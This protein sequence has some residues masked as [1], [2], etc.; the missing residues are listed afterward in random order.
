MSCRLTYEDS[1]VALDAV[2]VLA[3]PLAI[4]AIVTVRAFARFFMLVCVTRGTRP[5]DE[6]RSSER[7]PSTTTGS[8]RAV[9]SQ[10]VSVDRRRARML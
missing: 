8:I 5:K 10:P 2:L 4:A 9:D 6:P 3:A 1:A 7:S